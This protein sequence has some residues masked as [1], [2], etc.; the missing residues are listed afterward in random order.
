M[1]SV[2]I[3]S[4]LFLS[5]S[6]ITIAHG[7]ASAGIHIININ[8]PDNEGHTPFHKMV[9]E[10]SRIGRLDDTSYEVRYAEFQQLLNEVLIPGGVN[11][12]MPDAQGK[13]ALH[14]AAQ[15]GCPGV[16]KMLI[17]AGANPQV[18]DNEGQSIFKTLFNRII[19]DEACDRFAIYIAPLMKKEHVLCFACKKNGELMSCAGCTSALYCSQACQKTDWENHKP[20]CKAIQ[21][22]TTPD[23][24]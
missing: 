21:K 5:I 6:T 19:F 20:F 17:E 8:I 2:S 14:I 9:R 1:K 23:V 11:L 18:V 4:L 24:A 15:Y 16:A 3:F 10:L 12:N 13:T 22:R 7:S